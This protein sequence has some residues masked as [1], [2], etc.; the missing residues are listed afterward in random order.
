MYACRGINP[1]AFACI[2]ESPDSERVH[3][4]QGKLSDTDSREKQY[5]GRGFTFMPRPF[6]ARTSKAHKYHWSLIVSVRTKYIS[7][8][9]I[10]EGCIKREG[11][12]KYNW[13]KTIA[14]FS[15][16]F[17][18]YWMDDPH[19]L[20]SLTIVG[21]GGHWPTGWTMEGT[22]LPLLPVIWLLHRFPEQMLN[23]SASWIHA[24]W[25]H[26]GAW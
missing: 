19:N 26:K 20:V 4:K 25:L 3:R 7:F 23:C 16:L 17:I 14:N 22:G 21:R 9:R 18:S 15:Q 13:V 6:D 12:K 11:C 10:Q 5:S 1:D 2:W 24:Q 8:Y